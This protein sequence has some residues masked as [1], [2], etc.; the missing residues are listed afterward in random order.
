MNKAILERPSPMVFLSYSRVNGELARAFADMIAFV[1][2]GAPPQSPLNGG[3]LFKD[4]RSIQAGDD[5]T[6]SIRV[7]LGEMNL[8]VALVSS[9]WANSDWCMR[10]YKEAKRRQVTIVPVYLEPSPFR[11]HEIFQRHQGYIPP[12]D[13]AISQFH[14]AK[15]TSQVSE[16]V[17]FIFQR[18]CTEVAVNPPAKRLPEYLVPGSAGN[19]PPLIVYHCGAHTGDQPPGKQLKEGLEE[20]LGSE[21]MAAPPRLHDVTKTP[22]PPP[23]KVGQTV[24]VVDSPTTNPVARD[25]LLNY[26]RYMVGTKIHHETTLDRGVQVQTIWVDGQPLSSNRHQVKLDDRSP[27]GKFEDYIVIMRLPG[28]VLAGDFSDDAAETTVWLA[29]GTTYKGSSAGASLFSPEN[30]KALVEQVTSGREAPPAAFQVVFRVPKN[31]EHVAKHSDLGIPIHVEVLHSLRDRVRGDPVPT[32]LGALVL[33]AENTRDCSGIPL[34]AVHIDLVAA[35]NY[36]C[37][38]C[39]EANLRDKRW[40]FS[41]DKAMKILRDLKKQNCRILSFYGGEPTLHPNFVDIVGFASD[42]EF[43]PMIVTN[44]TGLLQDE[45]FCGLK[46]LGKGIQLRVSI[47]A[48]SQ[49]AYVKHHGSKSIEFD[50]E[51]IRKATLKL[52]EHV[53]VGISYLLT[54]E[55]VGEL[56]AA[57]EFWKGS[58]VKTF[59][60]RLPV[61]EGGGWQARPEHTRVREELQS[62]QWGQYSSDW[63]VIPDW[64]LD[65]IRNGSE[66]NP[67]WA[68]SNCYSAYYRVVISPYL[69]GTRR[70]VGGSTELVETDGAW[71]SLCPYHRYDGAYGCVYPS[72]LATWCRKMRWACVER[73]RP[74]SCETDGV[75][76]SRV[77]HNT[78]VQ[79]EINALRYPVRPAPTPALM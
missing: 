6:G 56:A 36:N 12:G 9:H 46:D 43:R 39:I 2:T 23:Y 29:Y 16:T 35:C 66:P 4:D 62:I 17:K 75:V 78:A 47:D 54:G 3:Q 20:F 57:L 14:G 19:E 76:C 31:P 61:A 32:G 79:A 30:F 40:R 59:N 63:L 10:E 48:H 74:E 38:G 64:L 72:D 67:V 1:I 55:N 70:A 51:K 69:D 52:A 60:P 33:E 27:S 28:I 15:Q 73:I 77:A 44:G 18:Y 26:Q 65:W 50:F 21:S 42:L 71:L 24:F 13:R 37:P 7:A 68:F 49:E 22:G 41:Y 45:I 34:T 25:V 5:W 53:E 11:L 8:F 58:A